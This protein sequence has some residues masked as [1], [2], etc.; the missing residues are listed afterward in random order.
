MRMKSPLLSVHSPELGVTSVRVPL[1]P[2]V[3]F[4]TGGSDYPVS[5]PKSLV[6]SDPIPSFPLIVDTPVSFTLLS[7]PVRPPYLNVLPTPRFTLILIYLLTYVR[8]KS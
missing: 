3:S 2:S 5:L 8:T 1:G 7:L 4:F 6:S